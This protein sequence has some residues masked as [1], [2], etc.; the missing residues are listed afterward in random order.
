MK[1]RED[2]LRLLGAF[3][4]RA[5]SGAE[6]HAVC[7]RDG[8]SIEE[9]VYD[10]EPGERVSAYVLIPEGEGP[11]PG[12]VACHQHND[13]Y[14]VGKSEPAGFYEG[15]MSPFAVSF[16]LAGFA[17]IC[18]DCLGFESRRPLEYE[19]RANRFLEGCEYERHLF[20]DYLLR[21]S[22]LQAKYISDYSRAVDVLASLPEV[23]PL[24]LGAMGHSLGGQ[25][26]LWLWW[27]DPRIKAAVCN[28]GV[29]LIADLQRACINHNYAMYL[30]SLL[31]S[32]LDMQDII[33]MMAPKPLAVFYG[34][35][36]P[37]FP[38]DSVR[39]LCRDAAEAYEAAGAG[40]A[41]SSHGFSGGHG[42]PSE[43]EKEAIAF[44]SSVLKDS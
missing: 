25:E 23:D 12:I 18:P 21:G 42:L 20:I 13:E 35:D 15:G 37:I 33:S 4:E 19:R 5:S 30:P 31:S 8:Y 27:Y 24:R 39:R 16:C 1:G 44:I 17:V 22:T 28:C 40:C 41:F 32:G 29:A 7:R 9:A 2:V 3:P 43:A 26:S 14:F 34:E 11:F 6:R 36:D 38:S 10:A